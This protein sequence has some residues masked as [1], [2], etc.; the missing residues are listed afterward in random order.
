MSTAY[1][2]KTDVEAYMN[3]TLTGNGQLLFNLLLPAMQDMVDQYCN[4]SWNTTNPITEYFD[5]I[6]AE[7]APYAQDTFFVG[8]PKIS[9]T[10][11]DINAPLAKG[12]ISVTV[13]G[14][15]WDMKYVYSYDTHVKLWL[16]PMTIM[17]P[18]PMGFKSIK[19]VYNSEAAGNVPP[20]IKLALIQ[21][22]ARK[23][24]T[25]S[26]SG[27]DAVRVQAGTVNVQYRPDGIGEMPDFV[28]QALDQYRLTPLDRF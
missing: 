23:I 9:Q 19:I 4:R 18:N 28:K 3:L 6:Q 13:G 14:V 16:R 5:A 10:P 7:T 15:E 22:I 24:Q 17:L 27:K 12:I 1:I 20:L 21:W 26:D 2:Q 8:C 11:A 25:S